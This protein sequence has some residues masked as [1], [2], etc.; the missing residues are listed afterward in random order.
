[1]REAAAVVVT[2]A[3]A[4][5]APSACQ[6]GAEPEP[7]G[8]QS[9][10]DAIDTSSPCGAPVPVSD[11]VM[12]NGVAV[13]ALMA[14]LEG[15][16]HFDPRAFEE[17]GKIELTVDVE[18]LPGATTYLRNSGL[19]CLT[20]TSSLD[21]GA[22]PLEGG[23]GPCESVTLP[24]S[25]VLEVNDEPQVVFPNREIRMSRFGAEL[26]PPSSLFPQSEPYAES[27]ADL[28]DPNWLDLR[29]MLQGDHLVPAEAEYYQFG[30]RRRYQPA[31]QWSADCARLE[32]ITRDTFASRDAV[33]ELVSG[34]WALCDAAYSRGEPHPASFLGVHILPDGRWN[35]IVDEGGLRRGAGFDHEGRLEL[36][37]DLV[38]GPAAPGY[39]YYLASGTSFG[40]YSS[41]LAGI[42]TASDSGNTLFLQDLGGRF[43]RTAEP[44]AEPE[45]PLFVA[46]ERAGRA[47]CTSKEAGHERWAQT[48][49]AVEQGLVGTWSTCSGRW[50]ALRFDGAGHVE[51]LDGSAEPQLRLGYG[52][53]AQDG[54]AILRLSTG[55]T[56]YVTRS[57]R[58]IKLQISYGLW[59]HGHVYVRGER[60]ALVLSAEP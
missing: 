59:G 34:T 20:R 40:V 36:A 52:I 44:L 11:Q 33:T 27:P 31:P 53:V 24:V 46:G 21:W 60:A 28:R 55:A 15:T 9:G 56:W 43:V 32:P 38:S 1:M 4:W 6:A 50:S 12:S 51:F 16:H 54:A 13:S 7:S 45:E 17:Y 23:Q 25:L 39:R 22:D 37:D 48:P 47:G 58:P 57:Q 42:V 49:D 5:G 30:F 41:V 8:G 18:V 14:D 35:A 26:W 19:D 29:F 3:L 10:T 2:C